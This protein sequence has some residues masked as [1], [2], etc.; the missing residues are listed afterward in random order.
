MDT[1]QEDAKEVEKKTEEVKLVKK[2]P[3]VTKKTKAPATPK[4]AVSNDLGKI[5][6]IGVVVVCDDIAISVDAAFK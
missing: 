1:E 2:S 3:M 4:L 5:K 6:Y